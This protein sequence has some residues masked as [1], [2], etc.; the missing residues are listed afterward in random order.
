MKTI[1]RSVL[2]DL[3]DKMIDKY[4]NNG[5]L[6]EFHCP[7]CNYSNGIFREKNCILCFNRTIIPKEGYWLDQYLG[8]TLMKTFSSDRKYD[9][10]RL[11]YW[12][13]VKEYLESLKSK[14]VYLGQLRYKCNEIDKKLM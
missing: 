4:T 6:S 10:I 5:E 8:C 1:E 2:I 7:I 13:Q 9:D 3:S 11:Q 14:N 12:Q